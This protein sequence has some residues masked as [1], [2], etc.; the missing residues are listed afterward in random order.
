MSDFSEIYDDVTCLKIYT[1]STIY[2]VL[3]FYS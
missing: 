2:I 3:D 1:H